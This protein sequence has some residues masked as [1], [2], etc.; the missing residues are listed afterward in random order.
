[1]K[2][3]AMAS[4]TLGLSDDRAARSAHASTANSAA[5]TAM[6]QS[7]PRFLSLEKGR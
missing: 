4:K 5:H 7:L 2:G 6:R 3:N 1:M